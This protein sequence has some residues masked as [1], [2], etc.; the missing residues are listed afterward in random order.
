MQ[1]TGIGG[2]YDRA[3]NALSFSGELY[4]LRRELNLRIDQR[5]A[6]TAAPKSH[7]LGVTRWFKRRRI[8]I[9]EAYLMVLRDLDSRHSKERLRALRMM[10]DASFHAKTLDMPLNT[11]RVQMALIKEAVK[12][13]DDRRLQL[14]LLAD[15]SASSYGRTQVVRSLADRLNIVELPEGGRK[16]KELDAGW[17]LHVHDTASSGR[18]NPTQLLIDAFIKGLSRLTI[19]YSGP[20][21]EMMEEAI[22]AGRIVGVA[23]EVAIEFSVNVSGERF[24][25]HALLPRFERGEELRAYLKKERKALA[26][27]FEA[28]EA[29]QESRVEAIRGLLG[30][31]NREVLPRL[32]EG[33]PDEEQYRLPKLK[34]RDFAAFVPLASASRYHLGEFLWSY[35]R[36]VMFNRVIYLKALRGKARS[37]LRHK[38]IAEWDY[39]IV[40]GRYRRL[41]E[42]Y[43]SMNPESLRRRWF[44][45]PGAGEYA[46]ALDDL[47][48]LR[49]LLDKAGCA[50]KLVSPLERGLAAAAR[51]LE[52]SRGLIDCVEVYNVQDSVKHDVSETLRLCELVN[53]LNA[54]SE[55][56]GTPPYVPVC[57]SDATGRSPDIPGMGFIYEDRVAG[58]YRR[59]YVKRHIALPDAAARLVAGGGKAVDLSSKQAARRILCMGK[60]SE[61]IGN[62]LGD[63]EDPGSQVV[64]PGRAV[65]YLNH[66]L[67]N[68][69]YAAVGFAVAYRF[70]GP[71]YA[72]LW[73][74]ITGFRNTIADIIAYRGARL[75][76]W[77]IG[78]VNFDNVAQSLFWTGFSVPILGF[79]K[80]RFDALWPFAA[81]GL[82]FNAAKF[83]FISFANGLY[84]AAHNKLRGFDRKVIR[85]NIFRSVIAWPFAAAFA[86]LG[87]LAGIP[88]IVQTKI[89]SDVIAGFIEGGNKYLKVVRLRRRDVEEIVPRAL[90]GKKEERCIAALDLLFLFREEPR[91]RNSLR[92]SAAALS[93]AMRDE[94]LDRRLV[95]Y[96]VTRHS[97]E[98]AVDLA[99]LV[100]DTLPEF[101]DWLEAEAAHGGRLG[102]G[103]ASP[104]GAAQGARYST[105]R[106]LPARIASR[107]LRS[108]LL[109]EAE[110][111]LT[112]TKATSSTIPEE[113]P[114]KATKST[115]FPTKRSSV[116][117]K[118]KPGK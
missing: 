18:K 95:D 53:S 117:S 7:P 8:S 96:I 23:V 20:S 27:L 36:P 68:L 59:R 46:S 74:G 61:G 84:L 50:L 12:H 110:P 115:G 118:G 10:I 34:L 40:D 75:K 80:A 42:E 33:F 14:E 108:T 43:R 38:R 98:V 3:V 47:G 57:G 35:Y 89:W 111:D 82:A 94:S 76:Q 109:K 104:R 28:L 44:A 116:G 62:R 37:D 25:F 1:R 114:T 45:A 32:N 2:L 92:A 56:D 99:S 41:R 64:P 51:L 85:A 54:R 58:R 83:F 86:P 88:S 4:K 65:R 13:R 5:E 52:S 78:S 49:R 39:G 106:T 22:E 103:R 67:V 19:A 11:A 93:A 77:T 15:F 100:A 90:E 63:G 48:E 107:R 21:T 71:A 9:A 17:D 70:I 72:C 55:A 73:L 102:A 79:V 31:F 29:N 113:A 105:Q 101:R 87:N 60:V 30:E 112:S 91:S 97:G 81:D 6:I 26:P 24:H 69:V 66:G 16:L